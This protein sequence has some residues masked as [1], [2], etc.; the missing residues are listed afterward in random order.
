MSGE[1]AETL[2]AEENKLTVVVQKESS[3]T[4][5]SGIVIRYSPSSVDPGGTVTLYVSTGPNVPTVPMP[6]ITG[7]SEENAKVV[8]E[9]VGLELGERK[10]AKRQRARSS[11]RMFWR[12][13]IHRREVPLAI[14][15]VWEK[16]PAMWR[17]STMNSR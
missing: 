13:Q 10:E 2:L 5:A 15:S 1:D 8:L 3:D 11:V 6:R 12:K 9:A 16:E 7:L 14:Q 17:R 4:V